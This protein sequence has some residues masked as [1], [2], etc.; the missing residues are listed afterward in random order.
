MELLARLS[1][2]IG[3]NLVQSDIVKE[4]DAEIY[5]Y[6]INQILVSVLNV[7]SALIIGLIFGVFPEITVFMAAYIPLRSFAGG[8]HAKTPLSCYVFSVIM[9]IVVSIGLKYLHIADWVYYA[10]L[11]AATL[12]VLVLSP[13]EDSNKPLDEIEHKVYKRRTI[14]IATVELT[15][16]MLLK[17][18]MLD[19]LF[20][21]TAYSF[22]VLSLMLIAGKVK[23]RFE[24]SK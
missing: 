24:F 23:K 2:K 19:D 4:E 21:A 14:L 3:N 6:G 10:V 5:I 1:R 11:V 15:L 12:V 13:V 18:L 16:A 22:V 9:L 8:Y 7:S 20:I 17:L